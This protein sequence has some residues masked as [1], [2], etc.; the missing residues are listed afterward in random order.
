MSLGRSPGHHPPTAG[1]RGRG[2]GGDDDTEMEMEWN[3]VGGLQDQLLLGADL[4]SRCF[5]MREA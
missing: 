1:W 5:R 3:C 4:G 2:G